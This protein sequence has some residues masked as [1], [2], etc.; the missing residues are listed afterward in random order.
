MK[1]IL[2]L[3]LLSIFLYA[4]C[5]KKERVPVSA[6]KAKESLDILNKIESPNQKD[7]FNE[8]IHENINILT[9]KYN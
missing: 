3:M 6:Y 8:A 7:A 5:E 1:K 9:K 4:G 2:V